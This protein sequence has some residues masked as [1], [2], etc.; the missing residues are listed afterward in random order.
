[1]L[2][3]PGESQL[4]VVEG[5][6]IAI[7]IQFS[8]AYDSNRSLVLTTGVPLDIS[9]EGLEKILARL[10]SAADSL[11]NRY[12]LEA[13]K[14]E[15]KRWQLDHDNSKQQRANLEVIVAANWQQRDRKGTPKPTAQQDAQARNFDISIQRCADEIKRVREEIAKLEGSIGDA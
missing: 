15:L 10:S 5:K 8:A 3:K 1:M 6:D 9:Q 13:L 14:A 2:D 4:K 7:G 12:R 11:N